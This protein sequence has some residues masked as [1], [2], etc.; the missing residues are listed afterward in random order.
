MCQIGIKVI[1][2]SREE[3][4]K[5][6]HEAAREI[7]NLAK[8]KPKIKGESTVLEVFPTGDKLKDMENL[9][10]AVTKAKSGDVILLKA[11]D[12]S[13]KKREFNLTNVAEL[14]FPKDFA[15]KGE[16]DAVVRFSY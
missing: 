9:E 12:R 11:K 15:L 13:G 2:M 1:R 8:N 14:F 16:K 5:I 3:S 4:R 7:S 10:N 6:I